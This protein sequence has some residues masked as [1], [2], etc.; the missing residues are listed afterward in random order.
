MNPLTEDEPQPDKLG[1]IR[2]NLETAI[3]FARLALQSE[4]ETE[5]SRYRRKGCDAYEE[6]LHDLNTATLSDIEWESIKTM[7][8]RFE[9]VLKV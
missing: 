3:D 1:L 5:V 2:A 7:M 9:S 6:A 4:D 8:E